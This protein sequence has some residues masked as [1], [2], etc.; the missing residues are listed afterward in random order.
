MSFLAVVLLNVANWQLNMLPDLD[1]YAEELLG[2]GGRTVDAGMGT[3]FKV[4]AV[5]VG[6]DGTVVDRTWQRQTGGGTMAS[7]TVK[8]Y[9]QIKNG[10]EVY[11][12]FVYSL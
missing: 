2:G 12:T 3:G 10:D 5:G 8:F 1:G 7:L 9:H 6:V 4:S 11:L